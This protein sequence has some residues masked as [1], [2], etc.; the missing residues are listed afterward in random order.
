MKGDGCLLA[1][2]KGCGA[3][4]PPAGKAVKFAGDLLLRIRLR[5]REQAT[6]F[7]GKKLCSR[8]ESVPRKKAERHPPLWQEADKTDVLPDGKGLW[9]REKMSILD[10]KRLCGRRGG[11]CRTGGFLAAICRFSQ[12]KRKF[13]E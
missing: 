10:R 7:G 2:R 6:L 4:P 13:V 9:R 5:S 12:K 8:K 11:T 1:P 3:V